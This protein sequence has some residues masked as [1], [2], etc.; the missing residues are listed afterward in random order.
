MI[1]SNLEQSWFHCTPS[2]IGHI[3]L[4]TE[5]GWDLRTFGT[6]DGESQNKDRDPH[7]RDSHRA[8]YEFK[9]K[10]ETCIKFCSVATLFPKQQRRMR[11]YSTTP[12]PSRCGL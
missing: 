12:H 4:G 6:E 11:T 3:F 5:T 7:H 8:H 10:N 1:D 2:A 9:I